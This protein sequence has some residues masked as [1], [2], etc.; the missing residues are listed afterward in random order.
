M[1]RIVKRNEDRE[2]IALIHCLALCAAPGVRWAHIKN[3]GKRSI[4]A[5]R[6]AKLMGLKPGIADLIFWRGDSI[7]CFLELKAE[8][9]RLSESQM[10]FKGDCDANGTPYRVAHSL[11]EALTILDDLGACRTNWRRRAA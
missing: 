1:T 4:Q 11:D 5:G 6:K 3:E 9:G 10:A 2:Q 7:I 8:K